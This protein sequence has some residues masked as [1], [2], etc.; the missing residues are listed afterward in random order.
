MDGVVLH[1]DALGRHCL[2]RSAQPGWAITDLR[3]VLHIVVPVV[4]AGQLVHSAVYEDVIDEGP[5]EDLVRFCLV[6]IGRGGRTVDHRMA[7]CWGL[8]E[9]VPV[10]DDLGGT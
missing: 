7:A 10:F 3:V 8:L 1:R 2:Q 9:V 5:D 6:Q 4:I